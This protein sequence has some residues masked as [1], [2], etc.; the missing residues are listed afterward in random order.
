MRREFTTE[1]QLCRK[2]L[3]SAFWH[4]TLRNVTLGWWG[5]ISFFMTWYFLATNLIA[6]LRARSELG[7]A[8]PR[9]AP[10]PSVVTGEEAQ[11]ILVPFEHNVRM[12]LRSGDAPETV[13]RDLAR[14]HGVEPTAAQHFVEQ[15]RATE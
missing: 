13:A 9:E 6:Y 14:T 8:L 12:L 2:C 11:R 5:T 3:N 10:R 15:I 1:G 4:H 7:E